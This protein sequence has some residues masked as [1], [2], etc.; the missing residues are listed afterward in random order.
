MKNNAFWKLIW[1]TRKNTVIRNAVDQLA[2]WYYKLFCSNKRFNFNGSELKY[3]YHLYN[4]TIANERAIELSLASRLIKKYHGKKILE[5]GNVL[6]HYFP[7]SHEIVDKYEK[8]KGVI[9][10]DISEF[11]PSYKYDLIISISTL[12][13]MGMDYGEKTEGKKALTSIKY[14]KNLLNKGGQIFVT[15]PL[16]WNKALYDRIKKSP[17]LFDIEYYFKKISP[18]NDWIQVNRTDALKSKP[19]DKKS[20]NTLLVYVGTNIKISS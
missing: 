2:V 16:G 10:C 13:H 7:V 3:F 14:L 1:M 20:G 8:A 17:G 15:I 18:L 5:V 4:C 9:N 19:F 6:S 11:V 12:E